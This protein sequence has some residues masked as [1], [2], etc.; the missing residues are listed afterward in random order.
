MWVTIP[1]DMEVPANLVKKRFEGGLYAAHMIPMGN[2]NEWEWL[3]N[4]VNE[5][6][7]YEFAGDMKDQE[8]MCGL[9]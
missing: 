6:E 8:H 5:N 3:L 1:D 7:K 2:F 4:W 9:L